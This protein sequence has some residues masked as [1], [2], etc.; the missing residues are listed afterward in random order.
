MEK[1]YEP[2]GD[3]CIEQLSEELC[4]VSLIGFGSGRYEIPL[5]IVELKGDVKSISSE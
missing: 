5:I 2:I 4:S 1:S 3:S